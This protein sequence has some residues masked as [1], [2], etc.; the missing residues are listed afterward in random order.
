MNQKI[1][2]QSMK[3]RRGILSGL[4]LMVLFLLASC[5]PEVTFYVTRPPQL[6][7]ENIETIELGSF[8]DVLDSDIGAPKGVSQSG[9]ARL[10]PKITD[11]K[12]NST[13]SALVQAMMVAGLSKSAQYQLVIPG[14]AVRDSG[15]VVPD[16]ASTGVINA[17]VKY[18]EQ[19]FEDAEDVFYVL[20]ATKRGLD[21]RDRA[22]LIAAKR[23][24]IA[25]AEKNRKGFRVNTPYIEKIAAMEVTF[26]L[27]RQS[28]GEKVVESQTLRSYYVKKWGGLE[29]S[30]H[31]SSSVKYSI[32]GDYEEQ[33][34]LFDMLLNKAER[35]E[36]VLLDP[37]EFLAL[38]GKLQNNPSVP[39]NSLDIQMR[40]ASHIVDRYLKKVSQYTEKTV[41]DVASGDA[42]AV[43]YIRGN[44][45]EKAINRLE[46]IDREEEDSFN[47]ALAYESI[48]E[49]VQAAKYY[50]EAL[51]KSPKNDTYKEA[52]QRVRKR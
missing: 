27:S 13:A 12:S 43:N 9:E 39:D 50:Q 41:L 2:E 51:E 35:I 25:S 29:T 36:K 14:M 31:L 23:G 48:G 34:S 11:F 44:A 15:G 22:L 46:N 1:K 16:A 32:Q 26:D 42:I 40:L 4:P 3:N 38:G 5:T 21:L 52:L 30:S 7:V 6:P 17:R 20:L 37:E 47:L 10:K 24:V 49:I 19:S 28:T 45:Y 18:F 33:A 8:T